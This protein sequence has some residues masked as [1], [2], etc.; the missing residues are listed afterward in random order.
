M[1]WRTHIHSNPDILVGKPVIKGT[2]ISVELI[3]E[4]FAEGWAEVDILESYPTLS[5]DDLKAVFAF[6]AECMR[7]EILY[8]FAPAAEAV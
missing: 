6:A 1:D 7:D 2:R 5:H 8:A 3:L 4:L